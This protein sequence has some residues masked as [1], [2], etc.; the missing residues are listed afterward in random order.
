MLQRY[1]SEMLARGNLNA[2]N[3]AKAL[4]EKQGDISLTENAP[5]VTTIKDSDDILHFSRIVSNAFQANNQYPRFIAAGLSNFIR[6]ANEDQGITAVAFL[7]AAKTGR[8]SNPLLNVAVLHLPS[9]D[10]GALQML[11]NRTLNAFALETQDVNFGLVTS[12]SGKSVNNPQVIA[13]NM[14]KAKAPHS[15]LG[16]LIAVGSFPR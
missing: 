4:R 8:D 16:T 5:L 11:F 3:Q 1:E 12:N 2:A 14:S 7:D 10:S 6:G 9:Y 15:P 13:D